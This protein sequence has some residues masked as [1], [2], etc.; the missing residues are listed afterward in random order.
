METSLRIFELL[1]KINDKPDSEAGS[2]LSSLEPDSEAELPHE[3]CFCAKLFFEDEEYRLHDCEQKK[4]C[5]EDVKIK[6]EATHQ[7]TYGECRKVFKKKAHLQKHL[8][9]NFSQQIQLQ[10]Y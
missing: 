5:Q 4:K 1:S 6:P 3:C 8:V 10:V 9:S 7:C 2:D